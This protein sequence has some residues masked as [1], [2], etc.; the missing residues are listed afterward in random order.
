MFVITLS[1]LFTRPKI[2]DNAPFILKDL[3]FLG[4]ALWTAG[5]ALEVKKARKGRPAVY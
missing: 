3:S 5:E 4:A 1:F 2:G